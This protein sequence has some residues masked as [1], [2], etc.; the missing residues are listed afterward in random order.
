[1]RMTYKF[2]PLEAWI[3]LRRVRSLL[4]VLRFLPDDLR[5]KAE[6][7]FRLLVQ[8]GLYKEMAAAFDTLEPAFRYRLLT[9]LRELPIETRM[10]FLRLLSA[11]DEDS[12]YQILDLPAKRER[13][14]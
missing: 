10:N 8:A 3:A 1:M 12:L 2:A 7:D 14:W 11:G 6:I 4:P 9:S 5:Q 13:R